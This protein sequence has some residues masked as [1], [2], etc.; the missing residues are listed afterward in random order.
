MD[1]TRPEEGFDDPTYGG[2]H[3]KHTLMDVLPSAYRQTLLKLDEATHELQDL[4]ARNAL[5]Q[6]E[7][8]LVVSFRLGIPRVEMQEIILQQTAYVGNPYVMQAMQVFE[9]VASSVEQAAAS[10]T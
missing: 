3:L 7:T 1:L 10:G 9:R 6:L 8:H 4:Y 5:P 2:D